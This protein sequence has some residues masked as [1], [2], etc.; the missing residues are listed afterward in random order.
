MSFSVVQEAFLSVEGIVAVHN[1]RIWGLTTDKTALSAHLAISKS[2]KSARFTR[3]V[4]LA[5]KLIHAALLPAA[6]GA[7][8][9]VILRE[10]SVAIRRKYNIYEMTLQVEDYEQDMS[11]CNQCQNPTQ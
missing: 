2:T 11:D 3:Q 4:F 5:I 7:N 9:K 8:P 6:P 1:L 10:A